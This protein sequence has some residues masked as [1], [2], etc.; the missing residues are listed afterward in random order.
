[1]TTELSINIVLPGKAG[2][3][4]KRNLTVQTHNV[5]KRT[6]KCVLAFTN[7]FPSEGGKS[8]ANVFYN[9]S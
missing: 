4:P 7:Y 8:K 9:D 5:Q 1:M 3:Q 6:W 2:E